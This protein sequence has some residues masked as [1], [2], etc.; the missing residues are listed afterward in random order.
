M[1]KKKRPESALVV[2]ATESG[3]VLL[4]E[5]KDWPGFWQSVTGSL[6]VDEQPV[7]A[8]VRELKEETGFTPDRG[9]W[10]D[11]QTSTVYPIYP[12][13]RHRYEAQVTENREHVFSLIL[14]EPLPPSLTEHRDFVWLSKEEAILK[15]K[16]ESNRAAIEQWVP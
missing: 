16:S 6:E 3:K 9:R 15:A 4:L 8:A 14:A 5:R 13:F 11:H 12:E 7:D 1:Q 10:T 2:L